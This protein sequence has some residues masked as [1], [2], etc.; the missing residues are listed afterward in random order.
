[1]IRCSFVCLP[2]LNVRAQ[3]RKPTACND[4][5]EF[6]AIAPVSVDDRAMP[7]DVSSPRLGSHSV[8]LSGFVKFFWRG[9]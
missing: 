8:A 1:V 3:R 4:R 5:E 6:S 2:L 7:A 9:L